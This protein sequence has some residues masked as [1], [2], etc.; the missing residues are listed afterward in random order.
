MVAAGNFH[1]SPT[2]HLRKRIFEM[3]ARF[4]PAALAAAML[5]SAPL[6]GVSTS[7]YAEPSQETRTA[8]VYFS[9]LDLASD[10]GIATLEQR[11]NTAARTVCSP[12][13][14]N[15]LRDRADYA[16]CI[17]GARESGHDA[18]VTIIADAQ[19]G[20]PLAVNRVAIGN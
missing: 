20:K 19:A 15:N 2:D 8:E 16:S 12:R 4:S 11:I 5:V 7:A 14:Q 17:T 13:P 1:R 10:A 6:I 9:D 3:T 18:M